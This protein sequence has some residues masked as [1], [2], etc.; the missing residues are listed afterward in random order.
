MNPIVEFVGNIHTRIVLVARAAIA[1]L[2]IDSGLGHFIQN[3]ESSHS[4]R[5]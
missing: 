5:G 3:I 4:C 1:K 2:M